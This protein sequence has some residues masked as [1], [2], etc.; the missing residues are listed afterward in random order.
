MKCGQSVQNCIRNSKNGYSSIY[1]ID[2]VLH[3]VVWACAA[4][5]VLRNSLTQTPTNRQIMEEELVPE[6]MPVL[7]N[8]SLYV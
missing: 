8:A 3:G 4:S 1:H 7:E 5:A 2:L 6:G